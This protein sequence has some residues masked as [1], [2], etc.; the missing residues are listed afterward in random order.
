MPKA[1]VAPGLEMSAYEPHSVLLTGGAGFMQVC[2]W[3]AS[4]FTE[5]LQC[6][7]DLCPSTPVPSL[8]A[9]T[10]SPIA[11]QSRTSL[12]FRNYP[13]FALSG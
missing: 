12:L 9:S 3:F 6:C 1:L 2:I 4:D 10:S 7:G 13:I 11:P 5:A 8:C